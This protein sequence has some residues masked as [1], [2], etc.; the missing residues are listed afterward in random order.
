VGNPFPL[1]KINE[2]EHVLDIGCGAGV[3][4]I[5]AAMMAGPDG[6]SVGVDI[7]PEMTARAES[8]LKMTG[9]NNYFK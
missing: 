9:I 1:G 3:D 7:V 2:G 4:T 5:M 8:N 6:S